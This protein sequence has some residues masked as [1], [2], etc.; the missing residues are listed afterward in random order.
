MGCTESKAY[1]FI[2]LF[3]KWQNLREGEREKNRDRREGRGGEKERDRKTH[4]QA[5]RQIYIYFIDFWKIIIMQSSV[6]LLIH[7][8]VSGST[9]KIL[10]SCGSL[11]I[12]ISEKMRWNSGVKFYWRYS[13]T[14]IFVCR[15]EILSS[16]S[17]LFVKRS[18]SSCH[19]CLIENNWTHYDGMELL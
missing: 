3:L 6:G 11:W 19:F 5:D 12:L 16:G 17:Q 2:L 18:F 1:S 8:L 7:C 10:K 13:K 4:R 15:M 14:S 9:S